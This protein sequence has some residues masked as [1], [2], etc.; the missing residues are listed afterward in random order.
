MVIFD[1]R[2]R[3]RARLEADAAPQHVAFSPQVGFVTSGDDGTL[4]LQ[5]LDGRV[6]RTTSIPRGSYNVQHGRGLVLTPSLDHGTLAVLDERARLL[7]VI[8][9]AGSCHDACFA[10]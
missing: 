2:G 10:A 7:R 3:H 8:Q 5:S 6:L 1:A 4:R 9:V